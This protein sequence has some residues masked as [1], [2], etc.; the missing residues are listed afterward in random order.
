MTAGATAEKKHT[1]NVHVGTTWGEPNV[2]II[3]TS[4]GWTGGGG[5]STIGHQRRK[6]RQVHRRMRAS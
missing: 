5:R 3:G 1:P 2:H 4:R 6:R